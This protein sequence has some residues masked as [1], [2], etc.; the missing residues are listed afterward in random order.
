TVEQRTL[1]VSFAA[2]F[3]AIFAAI[4]LVTPLQRSRWRKGQ[5]I[6]LTL[7]PVL[8]AGVFF[9]ALFGMYESDKATLTWYALALAAVYLGLACLL[10]RRTGADPDTL[11][12]IN[13]LHVGI[14]IAFITIAIPLKANAHWITIGWLVE[15]AALLLIAVRTNTN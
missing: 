7:L 12:L 9:A 8:N 1:T 15:S 3:A 6:T 11:N 2:L 13:L 14:A 5:S 4:P 10:R